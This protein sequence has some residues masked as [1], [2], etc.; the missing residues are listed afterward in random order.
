MKLTFLGAAGTVTGSRFLVD[1]GDTRLLVDCGLFQ[2]VKQLRERNWKPF[3]VPQ[4]S[5]DAVIV[6]HAHIDHTGYLPALVRDGYAGPIY[7]TRATADLAAIMLPDSAR[8]QEE[9]ARFA[10]KM[11]Y[12]RHEPAQPLYVEADARAA[13]R[14]L[15]PVA[16]DTA[17]SVGPAELR[18][19]RAGHIL[20][21]AAVTLAV[22]GLRLCFSGDVGRQHDLLHEAPA[23]PDPADWIVMES[24]YGDRLHGDGDPIA[25]LGTIVERTLRKK[26]TLIIPSFAVGRA[27]AMLYALYRLFR[28]HDVPQVPV[29]VDSPMATSVTRIYRR[30]KH[31]HKLSSSECAAALGF[32]Q[33]VSTPGESKKLSANQESKIII[34]ASG[35]ATGG[36]VLHH[37]KA[38]VGDP[39]TTV[40]L[41]GYQ[42]P[43]TRGAALAAGADSI[44]IH[45]RHYGVRAEVEQVDLYSAHADQKGL[46]TWLGQA[47]APPRQVFLVHGDPVPAD[48][49]RQKIED[50]FGH[51]VHVAEPM[52]AIELS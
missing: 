16:F 11:G 5:I 12:S 45:G 17:F 22:G 52:E 28:D 34:S 38:F 35:M 37:L 10:N 19:R 29:F 47:P 39:R 36:R 30:H 31:D 41:P 14:L 23:P 43:G 3:P 46:L 18:Y 26:G 6:T 13:L 7:C 42:A 32:A 33:F 20:G 40:L 24:T 1:H 4:E 15:A 25:T 50:R 8:I 48:T 2:G 51:S 49:L 27:Q 21:A 9:D 44:K